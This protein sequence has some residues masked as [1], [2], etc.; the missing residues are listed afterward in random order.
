MRLPHKQSLIAFVVLRIRQ[1]LLR[2]VADRSVRDR[3]FK[4]KHMGLNKCDSKIY[5]ISTKLCTGLHVTAG[6]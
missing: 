2:E 4:A 6:A 3:F 1:R 5:S